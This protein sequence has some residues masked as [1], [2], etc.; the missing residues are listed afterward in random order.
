MS[1]AA[2][3]DPITAATVEFRGDSIPVLI[4]QVTHK[5]TPTTWTTTLNLAPNSLKGTRP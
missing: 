2:H 5:I 3:L 1:K 4:T